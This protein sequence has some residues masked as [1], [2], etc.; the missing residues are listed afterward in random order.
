MGNL[1]NGQVKCLSPKGTLS[2]SQRS[3]AGVESSEPLQQPSPSTPG[4]AFVPQNARE[5]S[6]PAPR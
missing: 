3:W 5:A 6:R 4:P 1:E 2:P